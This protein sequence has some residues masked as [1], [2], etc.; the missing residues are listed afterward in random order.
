MLLSIDAAPLSFR[1]LPALRYGIAPGDAGGVPL[2]LDL[3]V[4]DPPPPRPAPAVVYLH[5]GGWESGDRRMALQPWLNPLL[6][7]HGFVAVSVTYRLTDEAPFPAQI[8]DVKAAIRWLRAH[9][10]EYG[11]DPARIGVWGDSAGAH[12]ASLLALTDR[13]AALDGGCGT[14]GVSSAV[15]AVVARCTPTDF[16]DSPWVEASPVLRKL[17]GGRPGAQGELRRLASPVCHAHPQ[18]PP[19]LLVHGTEDEL[20]PYRQATRLAE[21]LRGHGTEVHLHTVPGGYHN[22]CADMDLPWSDVPW[23]DLGHQALAFFT[24]RLAPG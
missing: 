20:V 5:G 22:L 14:P 7:G 6:A 18:A 2:Y 17:F 21:A 16:T 4:P 24:G 3:F 12:L 15:Q 11:V 23:T 1:Y 19:F 8:H 9:A 10:G 13:V